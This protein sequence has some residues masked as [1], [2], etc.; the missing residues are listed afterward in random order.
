MSADSTGD[1]VIRPAGRVCL[2]EGLPFFQKSV[3]DALEQP[4][5][6]IIL[7]LVDVSY[8]DSSGLGEILKLFLDGKILHSTR[9]DKVFSIQESL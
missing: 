4:V 7:D 1:Y 8:I 9:L 6:R 5:T 3:T 2:G